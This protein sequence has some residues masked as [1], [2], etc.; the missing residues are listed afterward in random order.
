MRWKIAL[1]SLTL[2]LLLVLLFILIISFVGAP[3][4]G[5]PFD[6]SEAWMTLC[7]S[8]IMNDTE[9]ACSGSPKMTSFSSSESSDICVA[10]IESNRSLQNKISIQIIGPNDHLISNFEGPAVIPLEQDACR[11]APVPTPLSPG[12]YQTKIIS[13]NQVVAGEDG[14]LT[15]IINDEPFLI[16]QPIIQ[17]PQLTLTTTTTP[18]NYQRVGDNITYNYRITNTG[19]IAVNS[20]QFVIND[21]KFDFPIN[22]GPADT[23]LPPSAS[24]I[25]SATY[26]I[27]QADIEAG[28][29]T[30]I[31]SIEGEEA[32][33]VTTVLTSNCKQPIGWVTYELRTTDT[34][35]TI[36][37]WYNDLNIENL[38]QANCLNKSTLSPGQIIY[39][40][41][42][43]LSAKIIGIVFMDPNHN[44]IQELL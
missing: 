8:G 32:A 11:M 35:D 40:P 1:V 18:D 42:T 19:T 10:W 37:Q 7:S 17:E 9:A 29:V 24:L 41:S 28:S 16:P 2:L 25:C 38:M 15:W 43:P 31:A 4:Y 39:V 23:I 5:T 20:P 6:V 22:C 3:G 34:L 30:S 12:K 44:D 33:Q 21:S 36:S 26:L 14:S 13:E 27:T